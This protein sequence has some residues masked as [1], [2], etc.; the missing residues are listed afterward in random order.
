MIDRSINTAYT[1]KIPNQSFIQY[2]IRYMI[3]FDN[4]TTSGIFLYLVNESDENKLLSD[5]STSTS[6]DWSI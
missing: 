3:C 5:I 4:S 6:L 2:E 1:I